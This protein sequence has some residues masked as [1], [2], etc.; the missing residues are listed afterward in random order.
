MG[1][2]LCPR[3]WPVCNIA[4]N[5]P[6]DIVPE[7]SSLDV[8]GCTSWLCG[9]SVR[10]ES[11]EV[12]KSAPEHPKELLVDSSTRAPLQQIARETFEA[13]DMQA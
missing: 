3:P 5:F 7:T 12:T 1:Y 13:F 11:V 8:I 10:P 9:L 2:M 4:P 6:G